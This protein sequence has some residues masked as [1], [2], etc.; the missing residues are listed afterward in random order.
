MAFSKSVPLLE[1]FQ[2]PLRSEMNY[3]AASLR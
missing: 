3:S 2:R 1:T